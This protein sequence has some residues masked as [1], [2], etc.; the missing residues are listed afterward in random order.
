MTPEDRPAPNSANNIMERR[1]RLSAIL[2]IIGL[3]IEAVSLIWAHPTA[4]LVFAFVGVAFMGIGSVVF[5][6]SLVSNERSS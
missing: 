6:Y 3:M 2:L 4:F 1:I 5:L